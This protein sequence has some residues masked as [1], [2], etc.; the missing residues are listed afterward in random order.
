MKSW[1]AVS[2]MCVFFLLFF[3]VVVLSFYIFILVQ[4]D[5]FYVYRYMEKLS[6]I[7]FS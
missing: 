1:V 2:I 5:S 6:G 4:Y 7:V 3:V